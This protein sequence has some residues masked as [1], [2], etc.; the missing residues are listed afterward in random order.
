MRIVFGLVIFTVALS[1][2]VTL[3]ESV[4]WNRCGI[5]ETMS[6]RPQHPARVLLMWTG[7]IA[8]RRSRIHSPSFS[9]KYSSGTCP[10]RRSTCLRL[11]FALSK[12]LV[13]LNATAPA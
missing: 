1:S 10:N 4:S 12:S 13:R 3:A 2:S 8:S 6:R 5:S 7:Q 9:P 11:Y